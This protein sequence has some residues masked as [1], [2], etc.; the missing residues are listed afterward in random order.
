[1][2]TPTN[3][4]DCC[5]LIARFRIYRWIVLGIDGIALNAADTEFVHHSYF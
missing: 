3:F 1:M 5:D 2:R 4:W